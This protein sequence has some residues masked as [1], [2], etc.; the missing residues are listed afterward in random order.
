MK[1]SQVP[2][3]IPFLWFNGQ[4]EEA[5]EF[6]M[7]V[8]PNASILFLNKWPEESSFPS[9][10]VHSVA[11]SLEGMHFCA[12]DAG[13][14]FHFN[15]SISFFINCETEDEVDRYWDLLSDGGGFLM[16]LDEYPFSPQYGWLI[17]RFGISWQIILAEE[18]P[19][20]K[21]FPSLMYVG[22]QVGKAREAMQLYTSIFENSAIRSI[23]PYGPD[24]APNQPE[25]VAFGDFTLSGQLFA[26]MDSAL[27]HEFAFS[28]AISLYVNCE[29]QAEIDRYWEAFTRNGEESMCGWLKDPYG[30]S[31][32]IVPRF[33]W[34]AF[35]QG[36]SDRIQ[37]MMDALQHM[38]KLDA[39]TLK[40][41]YDG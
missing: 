15:P 35:E 6:Y 21:I 9:N 5:V 28:E 36:D 16:P 14:A 27:D 4:A 26:S 8:F 20:Q 18:M 1:K 40:A 37:R 25:Y 12:F 13:P 33:F 23:F 34:D 41:A 19:D 3:I 39:A 17:D 10:N 7:G 38:R 31:W 32:Q 22:D 29:D 24:A 30:V 11:F 2:K